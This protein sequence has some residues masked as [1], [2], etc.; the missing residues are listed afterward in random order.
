MTNPCLFYVLS[1][2][3][4]G[5]ALKILPKPCNNAVGEQGTCMFV[6]ECIKTEGRHL[7]ECDRSEC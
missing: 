4:T 2:R 3:V 5:L 6:W 7:G 1:V